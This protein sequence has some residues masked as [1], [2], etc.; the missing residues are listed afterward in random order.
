[1]ATIILFGGTFDPIHTGHL[2]IAHRALEEVK[3]DFCVFLPAKNPRWKTPKT[4]SLSRVELLKIALEG[5]KE[6]QLSLVEINSDDK[7][8]YT[9]DTVKKYFS[10]G[11]NILYYLIGSDQEQKLHEWY[12]I[13]ALAKMVHFLVYY[14]EGYPLDLKNQENYSCKVLKGKEEMI[15]SSDIRKLRRLYT[16]KKVLD[17]IGAKRLYYMKDLEKFMSSKRLN[18]SLSVASL[19]YE[20]AL[21][22]DMNEE[23]AYIA[24]LIHDIAR[25]MPIQKQ[26][27]Y[28]KRY[29]P[30]YFDLPEVVFHQF[31]AIPFAKEIFDI[32][33]KEIFDAIEFHTTGKKNMSPLAMILFSA[34]KIEPLRGYDSSFLIDLCLKDYFQGFLEVLKENKKYYEQNNIDE[35]NAYTMDCYR[36]YIEEKEKW[37]N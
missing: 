8:N 16:P 24:G 31:V 7:I 19:A 21:R 26:K 34:D 29:Y 13:D 28:M 11:K 15:S 30:E 27:E 5:K 33:D 10:D 23:K 9:Y 4:D 14:R 25:E 20:I 6:F 35:K 22:N 17:A 32:Q 37:K 36:Y 12:Q 1:M 2:K 18:H 3:A